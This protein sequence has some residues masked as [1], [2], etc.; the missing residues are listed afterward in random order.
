MDKKKKVAAATAVIQHIR[1]EEEML[2]MQA[3]GAAGPEVVAPAALPPMN[4]WGISG[5]QGM[6]Q[7]QNM[8]QL[9]AFHGKFWR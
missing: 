9:K 2:M 5:R 6:M 8:M 7:M 3:Q 1:T 4:L